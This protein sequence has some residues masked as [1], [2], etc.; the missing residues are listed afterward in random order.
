M[1]S[2]EFWQLSLQFRSLNYNK[3]LLSS[4]SFLLQVFGHAI[5]AKIIKCHRNIF[6]EGKRWG[7]DSG[8]GGRS[9]PQ[10]YTVQL[11]FCPHYKHSMIYSWR[12]SC[13][14]TRNFISAACNFLLHARQ[15]R[16]NGVYCTRSVLHLHLT[17][18]T[19]QMWANSQQHT[20]LSQYSVLPIIKPWT[21]VHANS[22][23]IFIRI[24][25]IQ[26]RPSIRSHSVLFSFISD[27]YKVIFFIFFIFF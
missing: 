27:Y 21:D 7:K 26:W 15:M 22:Q 6:F 16:V 8:W 25:L 5:L 12:I 14:I 17:C 18:S 13:N 9:L 19:L 10:R 11:M 20:R 1:N 2:P 24:C 4:L 23:D 3:A